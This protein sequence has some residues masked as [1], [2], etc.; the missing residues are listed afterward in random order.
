MDE[1]PMKARSQTPRQR[2]VRQRNSN[3]TPR[4]ISAR[5]MAMIGA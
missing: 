5:S 2:S 3:A 1:P 4:K